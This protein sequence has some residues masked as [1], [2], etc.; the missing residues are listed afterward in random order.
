VPSR[1]RAKFNVENTFARY[2]VK[3]R[4]FKNKITVKYK[5]NSDRLLLGGGLDLEV[6]SDQSR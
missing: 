4:I 6:V 3:F 5:I 2:I 1:R